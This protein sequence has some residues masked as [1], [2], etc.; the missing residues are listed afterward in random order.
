MMDYLVKYVVNK[1]FQHDG[2]QSCWA[3]TLH[4]GSQRVSVESC[5]G[6]PFYE[7]SLPSYRPL[8]IN[9]CK[10]C[11]EIKVKYHNS[12]TFLL[13]KCKGPYLSVC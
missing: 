9:D 10:S 3:E 8:N 2:Y 7:L 11:T 13:K 1:V 6:I 12:R 5:V 4:Q